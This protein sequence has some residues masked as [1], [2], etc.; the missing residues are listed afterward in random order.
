[1]EVHQQVI[2][3]SRLKLISLAAFL[4]DEEPIQDA[5]TLK[6][7]RALADMHMD[8]ANSIRMVFGEN[9][10]RLVAI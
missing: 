6:R 5:D 1:M 3:E 4:S 9:K 10:P 2:E 8:A 7:W